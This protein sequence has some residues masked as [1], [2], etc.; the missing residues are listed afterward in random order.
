MG[1]AATSEADLAIE[2]LTRGR[3]PAGRLILEIPGD[4]LV[5]DAKLKD[6]IQE[7]PAVAFSGAA[8][9]VVFF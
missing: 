9:S 3:L 7:L 4:S 5:T 2:M 1:A 8:V 6:K